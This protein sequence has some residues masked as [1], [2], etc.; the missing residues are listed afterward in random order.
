[1]AGRLQYASKSQD[2]DAVVV[3]FADDSY[4]RDLVASTWS[5]RQA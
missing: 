1:M 2:V 3:L 5:A 4:W